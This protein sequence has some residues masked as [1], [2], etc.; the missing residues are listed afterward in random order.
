[1]SRRLERQLERSRYTN[2]VEGS[3]RTNPDGLHQGM[4]QLTAELELTN[5]SHPW[6]T[7][8]GAEPLISTDEN[9]YELGKHVEEPTSEELGKAIGTLR[10]ALWVN[11]PG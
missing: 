5:E 2:A 4:S 6:L 10:G 9:L 11:S 8:D 7:N 1:M 3:S